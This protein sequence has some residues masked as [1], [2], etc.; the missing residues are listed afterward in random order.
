MYTIL[1]RTILY[2]YYTILYYTILYYNILYYTILYYT[3]L[4]CT[5]LYCTVLYYTILCCIP[6]NRHP[7]LCMR[8][9]LYFN[10]GSCANGITCQFC[11]LPHRKRR[12]ELPKPR[13]LVQRLAAYTNGIINDGD[14]GIGRD[15]RWP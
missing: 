4:Y 10:A 11:H 2:L 3:I 8:P 12:S 9:C 1:Y 15:G 6:P 5:V 13:I 14:L 7:E